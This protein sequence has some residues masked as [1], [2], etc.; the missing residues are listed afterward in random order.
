MVCRKPK[1][2][3]NPCRSLIAAAGVLTAAVSSAVAQDLDAAIDSVLQVY[4]AKAAALAD[5]ILVSSSRFTSYSNTSGIWNNTRSNGWTSGFVPGLFWH[6]YD[7]TDGSLW[8]TRAEQ[9]TDGVRSEATESDNDTGFKFYCSFGLGYELTGKSNSDYLDVL[10]SAAE[11]LDTQRF[12]SSIGCYRSWRNSSSDP[13]GNPSVTD[14]SDN[15]TD[16]VFE[17]NID[18]MM[19]LEL[20][21]LV[22][23]ETN[24]QTYIDHA[25][26]HADRTWEHH[27]RE[28]GSTAHVVGFNLDGTVQYRRTHQG[29]Q[30]DSTWSRGQ[31]W[32]VYG[33]AMVYR[34]T[35]LQRML[36]RSE[37]CLEYF[38]S[39]VSSQSSD[40]IPYADLDAAVDS[41]NPKDT[42]AAAIVASAVLDLY[43][44][45]G[46]QAFLD[47]AEL[48]LADLTSNDYYSSEL[49][50]Q[51]VLMKGSEKWGEDEVGTIFGDFYLLEA[52][53][54]YR[55]A[56]SEI[57][58]PGESN[59]LINIST[60]GLVGLGGEIM[61]A[62]FVS[63]GDQSGGTVLIRGVG[64][65]LADFGV[66]NTVED[67]VLTIFRTEPDGSSTEIALND[68][69][70]DSQA[71]AEASAAVGAFPLSAGSKD[72]A[73]VLSGLAPGAYTVQLSG[74]G[75]A[76][77]N[78][79]I[80]VYR[81]E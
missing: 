53:L 20:M 49:T 24:I 73:L 63:Q 71:V 66:A 52:M 45:T 30:T 32:A 12:N 81:V 62:G 1:M 68:D 19:N 39:A 3:R 10:G 40:A 2:N 35:G 79:L 17:V 15:P 9:W 48:L 23:T 50:F 74:K 57:D 77:Q 59:D 33:Y 5:D 21:L 47:A 70:G 55:E 69:W 43:S 76:A 6:M 46:D 11:T 51:P 29:W 8:R 26:S 27:V 80:E 72:A 31:A 25:V 67:P 4:E 34:Y 22:G 75:T 28:N 78:G 38:L 44:L 13:V 36:D 7:Y 54:R 41:R 56:T 18:Q 64:P 14:S 37:A 58:P 65:T 16:M 60:R 61:I 42:S